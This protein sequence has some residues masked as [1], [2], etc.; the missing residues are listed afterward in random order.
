MINVVIDNL[1]NAW[2]SL[3]GVAPISSASDGEILEYVFLGLL[4]LLSV[5]F[6]FRLIL[7]LF[8]RG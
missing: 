3:V 6:I 2:Q 7:S 5:Q 1:K 4:V 8:Q